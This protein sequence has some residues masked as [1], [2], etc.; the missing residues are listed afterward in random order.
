MIECI[1]TMIVIRTLLSYHFVT[2]VYDITFHRVSGINSHL[3]V[4]VP[5]L[6]IEL[7][8]LRYDSRLI[9]IS[10]IPLSIQTFFITKD[11]KG[12][13]IVPT[14]FFLEYLNTSCLTRPFKYSS[15]IQST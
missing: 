12:N 11:Q 10:T 3:R 13:Y 15:S 2:R 4:I 7:V 14:I 5:S 1:L 6:V 8:T 9:S